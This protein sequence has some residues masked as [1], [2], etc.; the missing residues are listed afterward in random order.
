MGSVAKDQQQQL[1]P[2]DSLLLELNVR[3]DPPRFYFR[4]V[5]RLEE[6]LN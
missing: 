2:C 5:C 6:G 3:P 1:H 4:A